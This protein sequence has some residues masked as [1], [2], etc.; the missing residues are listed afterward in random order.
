M[1]I[2]QPRHFCALGAYQTVLAIHRAVPIIHAGPGC[3]DKL[4][5]GLRFYNGYQ[6]TGY[7]D[8]TAVPNS[9]LTETE[10]VF[11]GKQRLRELIESTRRVMDGDFFVVLT[12]CTAD[13]VGDDVQSLVSEFQ[14]EGIPI[15]CAETG[16]FK[17]STYIGYEMMLRAVAEQFLQPAKKIEADLVNVWASVPVVDSF[18]SGDLEAIRTLLRGIG[19][20]ANILYGPNAGGIEA[21]K[22]IPAAAFNLV[23]SPWVGVDMAEILKEKFGTPYIHIPSLPIGAK[24]TSRFLRDISV[25]AEL[26]GEKTEAFVQE[27]ELYFY[28]YLERVTDVLLSFRPN[29]PGRFFTALNANYALAISKFLV[30]EIG[31]LPGHQFITDAP[32]EQYHE[33]I[34]GEFANLS[35]SIS[36][37][38]TFTPDG[39][40]IKE[41]LREWEHVAKPLIIGS[42]WDKEIARNIGGSFLNAGLPIP[43]RLILDRTY[44]GYRGGLR[45]LEDIYSAVLSE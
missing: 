8:T 29:L 37:G 6:G 11:G 43:D 36:S 20:R 18:W 28:Q 4:S 31:L 26:K 16:G 35:D 41:K 39:G 3:C 22:K 2:Q 19:L 34:I 5:S 45:L 33:R 24:Q 32:P 1:I 44:V 17:G 9:N 25:F 27:Q 40:V 38:V 21:V 7:I 14:D 12:G 13:I 10:I 15:V 23:I 42:G 30:G